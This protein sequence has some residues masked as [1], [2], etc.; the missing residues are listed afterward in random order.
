MR[1]L[2]PLVGAVVFVDSMFFVAL[3]PLLPQLGEDLGLS[4]AA[5]GALG[6]AYAFGAL[7]GGIPSGIVA[8]RI[9]VK[10]TMLL[11]L[12]GMTVTTVTFGFA[13]V[14]WLLVAARLL[15]GLASVFSWTAALAWLVAA[16]PRGRRG[17]L[18]GAAMGSAIFGALFGPV[19]GA[20]AAETSRWLAF[21]SVAVLAAVLAAVAVRTPAAAPEGSQPV[22]LFLRP[23][24]D[25]QAR[26][27]IWLVALP[28]LFFGALS[29]LGPLRLD[30]LGFGAAAIGATWV[31]AAGLEAVLA[32]L[33]GRLSDRR[34]RIWPLAVGLSGAVVVGALLPWPRW[35]LVLAGLVVLSGL[36][37]GALW[38]PAMSLVS[39]RAEALGLDHAY[40]FALVNMAWAPGAIVGPA[41]GGAIAQATS[42]A[43]PYLLLSGG[44]A[45]TLA[46]LWRSA[47]SS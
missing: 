22:R 6:G 33:I 5:L 31:V 32:P 27:G 7:L 29:L 13:D 1:R 11:G 17:E 23:L 12:A 20:I 15:Q 40:A 42:D 30:E 38:A 36:T 41:A 3:T 2:L 35:G 24:R 45:L 46:W 28:G 19:L 10:P 16:A 9:G 8:A 37:V 26:I 44:C 14:Y 43:V 21:S 25:R 47:S 18:I 39:D 4:K 34:G